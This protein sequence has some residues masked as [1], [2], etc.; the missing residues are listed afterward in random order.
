MLLHMKAPHLLRRFSSINRS[1]EERSLGDQFSWSTGRR[2]IENL[3]LRN[4]YTK[5]ERV[6]RVFPSSINFCLISLAYT[7]TSILSFDCQSQ[8]PASISQIKSDSFSGTML[9]DLLGQ[10]KGGAQSGR[11]KCCNSIVRCTALLMN[12]QLNQ[13]NSSL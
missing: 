8:L 6:S 9:S 3:H 2:Y 4:H 11:S 12:L 5:R 1:D 7:T 10:S 13:I